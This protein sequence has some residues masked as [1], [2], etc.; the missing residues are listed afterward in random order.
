MGA[1]ISFIGEQMSEEKERIYI[2]AGCRPW[3]RRV[4]EETIRKFPG[5]WSFVSSK[6]ELNT[7]LEETANP[8]YI[9]FLH[10]N[11][12]VPEPMLVK[13]DCVCFHMADVPYARGGSP[14]Q[15]L[16]VRGHRQTKLTALRMVK[17]LDAGP[18]YQKRD[19]SLEGN[20]EEIYI[21]AT[22]LAAEMIRHITANDPVPV[23]QSGQVV[24]FPRRKPS[25]SEVP[26]LPA[27]EKLHDFIRMLDAEG[28]PAAFLQHGG[29]R[30]EFHRAGLYDGRIVADVTITPSNGEE[31]K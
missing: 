16:I 29:F 23:P 30:Y 11:W 4:F 1:F 28:Y 14:L 9:F 20:A 27:L 24:E 10:W 8:R 6:G 18:V 15:N 3:N 12:I 22:Y 19:L 26:Q 7:A 13:Y 2:V 31:R 5:Q 17:E 25:E 21:R